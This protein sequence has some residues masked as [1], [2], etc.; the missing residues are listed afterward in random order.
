VIVFPQKVL[1]GLF[2][3]KPTSPYPLY[4]ILCLFVVY[5]YS[6]TEALSPTRFNHFVPHPPVTSRIPPSPY[7]LP[8][9]LF[10]TLPPLFCFPPIPLFRI[11]FMHFCFFFPLLIYSFSTPTLHYLS[12][13]WPFYSASSSSHPGSHLYV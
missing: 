8:P 7:S 2:P 12:C 6:C 10:L 13:Y 5:S 4:K 11:P 3:K 9:R 1:F